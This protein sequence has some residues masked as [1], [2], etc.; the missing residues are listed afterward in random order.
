MHSSRPLRL[1]TLLLVCAACPGLARGQRVP[2]EFSRQII[3]NKWLDPILPEDLPELSYPAWAND[4][5]KARMQ[6]FAGRY[7]RSLLTLMRAEQT[8]PHA[9]PVEMA[10]IKATS[11][12]AL[13]RPTEALQALQGNDPRVQVRRATILAAL[14]RTDEALDQLTT[15]L[16][17][18]PDSIAARFYLGQIYEQ[19]GQIEQA[20]DAY[21]WFIVEPQDYLTRWERDKERAFDNAEEVTLIG[22]A[23]DRWATLTGSYQT[24]PRL[25]DALLNIFV[26]AYDVID[27]EYWPAH[28]AAAEYFLSHDDTPKAMAELKAALER[29]PNDT[30]TLELIGKIAVEGW[31]F[32]RADAAIAAIR[33]VDR[34]SIAADLLEARNLLQQRRPADAEIPLR[35]V[36]ARQPKHLEAMG[37]LAATFALRLQDDKTAEILKQVEQIDPDNATAYFEVADQLGAMRQYPRAI[38]MYRIAIERAPWWT[39][40]RNGLGLLYTQSGDEDAAQVTLDAA[41][42]LDP[43][44]LRTTNYLRLLEDLAKFA[45]QETEHFVVMYDPKLDPIIPEYFSEYLEAMHAEV[46][47]VFK[48][49]P[50]VKTYIEVFPTHDAFS[51]RTTGSPWIGTVGA[52]TGRVIALVAPRKGEATMGAFNWANV[53]RHEYTHTVTL[54]AT[55]NRIPHWMTEGLA[56]VQERTPMKW[57]WVP[58]LYHAVTNDEL[59]TMENLTWGFVR[60]KRPID[61]S[62]AYAQSAWICRYI[63]QTFGHDVILRMLQAFKD[64]ASE[65]QVFQDVLGKSLSEFQADFFAWTRKQVSTWGYDPQ[66]SQQYE[67]LRERGEELIK[68]RDYVEAVKVWQQILKLRP[69]D[70]LPHQRLAGLYLT[71]AVNDPARAIEHLKVLHAVELKDNRY[72]K[73]ISRLYR[74]INDLPNARSYALESVYIDPYD[75]DAHNLLLEVAEKAGDE[76]LAARERRM[77]PVLEQWINA[78]RPKPQ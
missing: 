27:R 44:N 41:H 69:V 5:D 11:L 16:E 8:V 56:V 26:R 73:R 67:K 29:N 54:A 46:T 14:G 60:P 6:S 30:R 20:R 24:L 43:Y 22:R 34:E 1:V 65:Q 77:I 63:E 33:R 31:N 74:D 57:D 35:R 25:H 78:N 66:T 17:K 48:T 62:L 9:D 49:E 23:I 76:T 58:M 59:F 45:R 42:A 28:V 40:A 51:V 55:E 39:A 19:L 72:A 68:A 71:R 21:G 3:P 7:K 52:S 75:L 47:G 50:P 61:R 4:L 15:H 32:D 53:L 70:A 64:G 10:L 13:G 2:D 38:A 18:H 36:L 37:L 12:N